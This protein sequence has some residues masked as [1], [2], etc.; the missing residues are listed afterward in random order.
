MKIL[1]DHQIFTLQE[2]GGISRSFYELLKR[3]L[4]DD[5]LEMEVA[6]KYSN[7]AYL[8]KST[9]PGIHSFFPG[10]KLR[11]R[12]RFINWANTAVSKKAVKKGDFD[13]FHPTYYG[14]E[15]LKD[16]PA[17][18]PFTITFLDTIHERLSH[19]FEGLGADKEIYNNKKVLLERA[20]RVITISESTKKDIVE[21]FGVDA[22]KIEVIYLGSS[23]DISFANNDRLIDAPYILFVGNRSMYKNFTF[24]LEAIAPVL[25]DNNELLL[26][27]AGGRPFTEEEITQIKELNLL[28]QVIYKNVDDRILANLYRYAVAFAFPSL[29]EG[30]GIPVLEALACGCPCLLSNN[31]SLPEVAGD[32][33]LYFDP[34]DAD[35]IAAS[36]NKML[37]SQE[38]RTELVTKGLEREKLFSWDKNYAET[39]KF[40]RSLI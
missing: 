24:F 25:A 17:N 28:E 37:G 23:F 1:Y 7:N 34:S 13:I 16:I 11:G 39:V 21:I 14:A 29:Y 19:K 20:S 31:S 22:R 18:K 40:Y 33:A 38:L 2:F 3:G 9:Y 36:L 4:K 12:Y 35:S 26:V 8:N 10:T 5:S 6:L 15:F 30:F 32:A 27:C